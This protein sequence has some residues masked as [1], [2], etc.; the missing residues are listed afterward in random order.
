MSEKTTNLQRVRIVPNT[1]DGY[2]ELA[3]LL[4]T[5]KLPPM[6]ECSNGDA[7]SLMHASAGRGKYKSSFSQLPPIQN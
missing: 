6:T 4:C 2:T 1:P 3:K 7:Y 5:L